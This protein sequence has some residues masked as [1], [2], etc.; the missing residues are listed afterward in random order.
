MTEVNILEMQL[1]YLNY[2][3]RST[4]FDLVRR[5]SGG[6]MKYYVDY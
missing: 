3:S 4:R 5:S 6:S 1:I 2:C